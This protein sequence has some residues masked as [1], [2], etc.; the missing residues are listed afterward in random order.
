MQLN[1]EVLLLAMHINT[2]LQA[3]LLSVVIRKYVGGDTE[4][5]SEKAARP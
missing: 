3:M 2:P 1:V 5:M 4:E